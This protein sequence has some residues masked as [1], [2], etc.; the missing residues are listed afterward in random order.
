M[1]MQMKRAFNAKFLTKVYLYKVAK[2]TYDANNDWVE[3]RTTKS[4]IF[5]VI[6]AGNK[7]SQFEEGE[8]IHNEQGGIRTSNFRSLYVL[9]KYSLDINDKVG[10]A[11]EYYNVI[12]TSDELV[13]GFHSY[14][15]EKSK[16]WQPK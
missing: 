1:A 8:A 15:I 3:G 14:T 13:Y 16:G 11:G 10:I 6:K 7:F 2:G 5:G 9:N 4:T 12:Q